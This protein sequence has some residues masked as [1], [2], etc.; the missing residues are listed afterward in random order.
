[1]LVVYIEAWLGIA[2]GRR[3]P[4]SVWNDGERLEMGGPYDRPEDAEDDAVRYC[5]DTLGRAPDRILRL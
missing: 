2:G 3:F 1:M 4:W 5:R